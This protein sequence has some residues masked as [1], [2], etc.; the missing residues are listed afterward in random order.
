MNGIP[1]G[2]ASNKVQGEERNQEEAANRSVVSSP[3]V[4]MWVETANKDA[5]VAVLGI[6]VE[7]LDVGG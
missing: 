1:V 5:S 2:D 4:G 6:H 7:K 3:F